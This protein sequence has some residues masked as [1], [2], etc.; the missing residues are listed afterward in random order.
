MGRVLVP[1]VLNHAQARIN[2]GT[3]TAFYLHIH[4]MYLY[5]LTCMVRA[6]STQLPVGTSLVPYP[7][8]YGQNRQIY[9]IP[10]AQLHG[11]IDRSIQLQTCAN[12]NRQI[13]S[14]KPKDLIIWHSTVYILHVPCC[15]R[16]PVVE[17]LKVGK[18][19][20][21]VYYYD[22][23]FL[24]P[25]YRGRQLVLQCVWAIQPVVTCM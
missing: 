21:E 20:K 12:S 8:W 6:S 1:A 23:R 13:Y 25:Q 17:E 9:L 2:Y 7:Y 10:S 4:V 14:A 24:A 16:V 18:W 5:L 11:K 15:R 19:S 3:G 22:N